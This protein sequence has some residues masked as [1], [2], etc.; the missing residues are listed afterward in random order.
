MRR[1]L[2]LQHMEGDSPGRFASLFAAADY[3]IETVALHDGDVIP[4]LDGY[5]L[6][7]VLGGAMDVWQEDAHP[8]LVAEKQAIREWVRDRAKPYIGIC[9][10]H[11]LLAD[12][13]GG[14]V[15]LAAVAEVGL[16]QIETVGEAGSHPFLA[17]IGPRHKVLQ[18]HQ[19]EV[20]RLPDGARA[21]AASATTAVQAMAIGDHALGVQFHCEWTLDTIRGWATVDGWLPA[22]ER[23][24][25]PG[26]HGRMLA[27]A[28][29]HMADIA[30]M[31]E[32][33]YGNFARSSG[34]SR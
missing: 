34:L 1:V 30:R 32:T 11:Q 29:P 6:L 31:T 15:G 9:L 23:H 7:F 17:G 18:W 33:L 27:A 2:V 20:K 8:W 16:C 10:G 21:L 26:G 28:E 24:L 4:A 19:A 13:L 5:D 22:L 12:A 14:E 3:R 25:G